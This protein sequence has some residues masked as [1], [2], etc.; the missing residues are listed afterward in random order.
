MAGGGD[1]SLGNKEALFNEVP[2]GQVIEDSAST[3]ACIQ[4]T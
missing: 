1:K 2:V 3:S 4:V